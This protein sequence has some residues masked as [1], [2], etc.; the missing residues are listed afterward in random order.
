MKKLLLFLTLMVSTNLVLKAQIFSQNFNGTM[1]DLVPVSPAAPTTSQF[2]AVGVAAPGTNTS[3]S[4][5]SGKLKLTRSATP[6]S[7]GGFYRTTPFSTIPTF[8]AISFDLEV[9]TSSASH[10]NLAQFAIGTLGSDYAAESGTST[11][12]SKIHIDAVESGEFA[13]TDPKAT[14]QVTSTFSGSQK[15]TW[16]INRSL[17]A[18]SYVGPDGSTQSV[19]INTMDLWIGT[20]LQLDERPLTNPAVDMAGFKFIIKDGNPSTETATVLIDNLV[21][22]DIAPT[23]PLPVSLTSFNATKIIDG[24]KLSWSTVS[25]KNNSHFDIL[26]SSDKENFELITTKT[27]AGNS[28]A[29]LDYSYTDPTPANGNNYYKLR[30]VDLD[31]NTTTYDHM[32]RS[33]KVSLDD[34]NQLY[35]TENDLNYTMNSTEAELDVYTITGVKILEYKS[36]SSVG[37]LSIQHLP[38]GFYIARLKTGN[39]F[40]TLKFS[41]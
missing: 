6:S 37:K 29:R 33:V 19:G 23:T 3:V 35:I 39:E 41:K 22:S 13:I 18:V 1:A 36:M 34:K 2:D 4:I 24:V 26:R 38:K 14:Q 8:V 31:G 12:T 20:S 21:I 15:L 9:P 40:I 32:I 16:L 10:R 11:M 25:E 7:G 30:Q 5:E 27:G 17:D 28:F